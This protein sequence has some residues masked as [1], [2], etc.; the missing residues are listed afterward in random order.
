MAKEVYIS[1]V[2]INGILNEL[3]KVVK[4][5]SITIGSEFRLSTGLLCLDLTM[6]GGIT[7]GMY[8][9][10]GREQSA[11]TTLAINIMG[12][13][14]KQDVGLRVLWDA[15][16]SSGSSMDYIENIFETNGV[17]ADVESLFGTRVKGKYTKTP[18]VY[19]RDEANMDTFFNWFAGLL[20]R[21]P[22]KRYEA[23]KWWFVYPSTMENKAKYKGQY[24]RNIS[25]A[26]GALYIPAPDGSLQ[27]IILTDSYPALLP[28]V[29]EESDDPN[30]GMALNAREFSKNVPRVKGKLRAKRV[31]LLG[32]NQL[33]TNPMAKFVDPNYEPGGDALKFY[34]DV[35]FRSTARS[36]STCPYN[37][38]GKGQIEKEPSVVYEGDDTYRYIHLKA[39]K[40]KLSVPG[41]ET[42]ARIWIEDAAGKARGIDPVWDTFYALEMTGQVSGKR[43]ALSLNVYGLGQAKKTIT[44]EQFKYLVLGSKEEIAA[45]CKKIGYKPVNL[46]KGLFT[47]M[48]KG[49]MEDLYVEAHR[50]KKE[51]VKEVA[52][53]K[54]DEDED[55]E[56]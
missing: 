42:W 6:G 37:P 23:N 54:D 7:A 15:E 18:M 56:D 10:S 17:D 25:A 46:R 24:D 1:P 40:N 4:V 26:N 32:I 41:R 52:T 5:Q 38:K 30:I 20:R 19:Y 2:N 12:A 13:S 51:K 16:N 9:F 53:K 27:A 29:M 39:I 43:S 34:S 8:T 33:R 50:A 3:E 49:I 44:W 55:D 35:R 36:L 31:A 47:L 22:D 11:K 48:R 14:V 28:Q 45:V 21:L